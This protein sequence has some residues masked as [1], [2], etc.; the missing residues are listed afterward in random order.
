LAG[1]GMNKLSKKIIAVTTFV[2]LIVVA[3]SLLSYQF[4]SIGI[5]GYILSKAKGLFMTVFTVYTALVGIVIFFESKDPAKTMAWLLVL[6]VLPFVG[7]VFYIMFGQSYRRRRIFA[8]KKRAGSKHLENTA[9]L[10]KEMIMDYPMTGDLDSPV[11]QRLARLLLNNSNAI[12]T[13]NNE[14]EI[15]SDGREAYSSIIRALRDANEQIHLEYFIIKDDEIGNIMRKI[16]VEKALAGVEVRLIYDSVGCWRLSKTY[17]DSLKKSGVQ[18]K[19]FFPVIFPVLSRE[20]NYRNHRKIVVV[21]G[22]IGFVGGMNIGD[23]YLGNNPRLG[24]WRDTH[25][26][27]EGEG[28]YVLQNIFLKDWEFVSGEYLEGIEHYPKIDYRG[29][30]LLQISTSGPDSDWESI[31]Q[32]YFTMITAAKTRIWIMTPYL[33]PDKSLSVALKTAA[34]SGLDVRIIIP[35]KPDHFT[36]YWASRGNIE[37]LMEAGVRIYTY[38]KGFMHSKVFIVDDTVASVGTA[39]LDIRSLEINFEVNAF[40]YNRK[41]VRKLEMDFLS[42]IEESKEVELKEYKERGIWVKFLEA[43]GR[44]L[45]PL[46]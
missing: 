23:E 35:S 42:D 39:N 45:S 13:V 6:V 8:K 19:E 10:Q 22:K 18:V 44:L 33:V 12:F 36:V 37:D 3:I 11:N 5:F 25:M 38:Q 26:R 7:F 9:N 4:I 27:I 34:L 28:V 1:E 29:N 24:Y 17:L 41:T 16:L 30:E 14:T 40:I 20:L 21:D 46:L 31:Q 15:Y 43:Y 2:I 32:A